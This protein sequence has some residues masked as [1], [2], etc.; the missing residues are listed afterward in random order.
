MILN[1]GGFLFE[2]RHAVSIEMSATSGIASNER[3]NNSVAHY[4]ANLGRTNLSLAG[5]T[6]PNS[7]DGNKKLKKLWQLM[8]EAKPLS[9]VAG[10]GKYYGKFVILEIKETR[11]VWTNDAK[12]LAQEFTI[13]LEQSYV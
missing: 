10:D 13:N 3:I 1:L 6:L 2:T 4:R 8:R 9:L 11:S 12:F 5:R 7:G